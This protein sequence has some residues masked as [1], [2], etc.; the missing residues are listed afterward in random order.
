MANVV[1]EHPFD[2][3]SLIHSIDKQSWTKSAN[4]IQLNKMNIGFEIQG[5]LVQTSDKAKLLR[6]SWDS[7][8][9][10]NSHLSLPLVRMPYDINT[11]NPSL[12]HKIGKTGQLSR[13]AMRQ[14]Y[15]K[16][17]KFNLKVKK[18]IQ[19]NYQIIK[20][21]KKG[22]TNRHII[23]MTL[24]RYSFVSLFI[25][26]LSAFFVGADVPLTHCEVHLTIEICLYMLKQTII[27]CLSINVINLFNLINLKAYYIITLYAWCRGIHETYIFNSNKWQILI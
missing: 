3:V 17:V 19:T 24:K 20:F 21:Y 5:S 13:K 9:E 12:V 4:P 26:T 27:I 7:Y 18:S 23:I 16:W 2:L 11:C 22:T 15:N 8:I 1:Q 6:D 14:Y 10:L 25:S